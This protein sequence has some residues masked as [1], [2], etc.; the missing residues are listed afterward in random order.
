[1]KCPVCEKVTGSKKK[2]LNCGFDQLGKEFINENEYEAWFRDT[3]EPCRKVYLSVVS[4]VVAVESK[5]EEL[6]ADYDE[7][8]GELSELQDEYD[9]LEQKL[10]ET[11]TKGYV[12]SRHRTDNNSVLFEDEFLIARIVKLESIYYLNTGDAKVVTMA[13]ENKSSKKLEI[14]LRNIKVGG[15][16]NQES[17]PGYTLPGYQKGINRFNLIYENKLPGNI[18]EFST[19]QFEIYYDTGRYSDVPW[20]NSKRVALDL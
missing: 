17:T 10:E 9:E 2:C 14:S 18:E 19:V 16:L 6:Q 4:Q 12:S 15:Y 5:L 13:F 1:M 8:S 3:V 20:C 7:L 11:E